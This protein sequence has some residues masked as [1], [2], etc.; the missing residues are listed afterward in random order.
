MRIVRLLPGGCRRLTVPY[1][2]GILERAFGDPS[3][4]SLE[5]T[6]RQTVVDFGLLPVDGLTPEAAPETDATPVRV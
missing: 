6:A 2:Q 5:D 4:A 3:A 1:V